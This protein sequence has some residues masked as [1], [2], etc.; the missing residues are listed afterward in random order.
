MTAEALLS[1]A[2]HCARNRISFLAAQWLQREFPLTV[3]QSNAGFYLG[4]EDD[5]GP[6]AR[7]SEYFPTR[8]AAQAALDSGEWCQ[9]MHP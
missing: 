4:C 3:C 8:E 7:D 9:R 1:L 6:V 2:A 5:E